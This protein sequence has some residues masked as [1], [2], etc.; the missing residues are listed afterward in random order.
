MANAPATEHVWHD[1]ASEPAAGGAVQVRAT[2]SLSQGAPI[3]AGHFPGQ[4]LV[5]GVVLLDAVR[6]AC[7]RAFATTFELRD[8]VD[9]RFQKPLAPDERA[10]LDAAV[11][12]EADGAVVVE[13]AW[14]STDEPPARVAAFRLRLR[15]SRAHA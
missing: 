2:W 8:V 15:E 12:H 11:T 6:V 9:V 3:L 5:P 1:F 7:E 10:T 13:G 4:P 14:S